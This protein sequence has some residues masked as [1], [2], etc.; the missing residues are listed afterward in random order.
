MLRE[1]VA[2]DASVF[3]YDEVYDEIQASKTAEVAAKKQNTD[4]KVITL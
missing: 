1:A 4:K 3:Q 2:E